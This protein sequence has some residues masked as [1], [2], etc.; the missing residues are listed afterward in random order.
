M[1]A[2]SNIFSQ[3]KWLLCLISSNTIQKLPAD[4]FYF[5]CFAGVERVIVTERRSVGADAPVS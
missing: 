4:R 3:N 1:T 5:N 2:L